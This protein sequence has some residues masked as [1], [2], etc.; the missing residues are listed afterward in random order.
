VPRAARGLGVEVVV[1]HTVP[2]LDGLLCCDRCPH[3]GRPRL[4]CGVE[5]A[6]RALVRWCRLLCARAPCCA[7]SVPGRRTPT[8]I[9]AQGLSMLWV[10]GMEQGWAILQ[11]EHPP[12]EASW[13]NPNVYYDSCGPPSPSR[14][15][16]GSCYGSDRL[17]CLSPNATHIPAE[18]LCS[19]GDRRPK[20]Q[21]GPPQPHTHSRCA[22]NAP[23]DRPGRSARPRPAEGRH[24]PCRAQPPVRATGASSCGR[25]TNTLARKRVEVSWIEFSLSGKQTP[26][27][28]ENV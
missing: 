16:A 5:R 10:C 1:W 6:G 4:C 19:R 8:H 15:R 14:T 2:P 27:H 23:P 22:S 28:R 13:R 18:T 3:H 7:G 25:K 12:D 26:P 21:L 24:R 20:K 17:H 9:C 11:V